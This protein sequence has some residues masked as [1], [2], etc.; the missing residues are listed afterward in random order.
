MSPW[1]V[2]VATVVVGALVPRPVALAQPFCPATATVLVVAENLSADDVVGVKVA[3]ELLD[4]DAT[5]Q[6]EGRASY[7]EDLT[8]VGR[9]FVRCGTI[10]GL[11]PGAWANRILLGVNDP[12][13]GPQSQ[14]QQAVFIAG[15]PRN[16]ANIL[17]WTVYPRTYVVAEATQAALQAR[18]DAAAA[19]TATHPGPALITFSPLAFPGAHAPQTITLADSRCDSDGT[20]CAGIRLE[21]SRL[22]VDAL[23]PRGAG[24]A[25]VL[26]A[27]PGRHEVVR[28]LGGGNVLRGLRLVGSEA[29]D[30]R[31]DTLVLS[32]P[33]ARG[34]RI[35]Q[36]LIVGPARGDAVGVGERA[37]DAAAPN[38]VDACEVTQA[39]G[40]GVRVV[41]GA[42]AV[43]RG[44][45]IHDNRNGGVQGSLGGHVSALENVVQH[46][47]PG[48][49]SNGIAVDGVR[50]GSPST[51]VT[52]ANVV[53]FAGA[54]GLSVKDDALATFEHD[55]VA[56]NQFAGSKVETTGRGPAGAAPGASFRGVALVCNHNGGISGS[57]QSETGDEEI[58]VPCE[59]AADCCPNEDGF[60]DPTCPTEC[61]PLSFPRGFGA[62]QSREGEGGAPVVVYGDDVQPGRNAFAWNQN[63]PRGANLNLNVA[64][65]RVSA[66]GN[67]WEHC[68][69]GAVCDVAAVAA[70]DVHLAE[71]A[72]VDLGE[73]AGPRAGAPVLLAVTP[74]RPRKGDLVRVFGENFNAVEGTTCAGVTGPGARPCAVTNL[75]VQN[76]NRATNATRIRI[77]APN[78]A[79]ETLYPDAVTPTMLAFHMPFDCF[80]PLSLRVAKLRADGQRIERGIPFCD[81]GGCLGA[82]AGTPCDDGSA[83][84]VDDRC[85]GGGAPTCTGTA[86]VCEGVCVTCNPEQGCVPSPAST[87]CDDGDVCTLGDHCAGREPTCVPGAPGLCDDG[88][89]CTDGVCEPGVGCVFGFNVA[90]CND[91]DPCTLD[92]TCAD[93][94]CAG[95]PLG[96]EDS[97]VCNGTETCNP[98]LGCVRGFP[99][100]CGDASDCTVP[101]VMC[102][103]ETVRRI[104]SE[105]PVIDCGGR[106]PCGFQRLVD[107]AGRLIERA[108]T[109]GGPAECRRRLRAATRTARALRQRLVRLGTRGCIAPIDRLHLLLDEALRLRA[110]AAMLARGFCARL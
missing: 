85:T 82:A 94:T 96:C 41:G 7:L 19:Y 52:V 74:P 54:R 69:E 45:C 38:V 57:C 27:G 64:G 42:H 14:G 90:R 31:H 65:A 39:Q 97:D 13:S 28:V 5:C 84:T 87:P 88:D 107:R 89:P 91:G 25:V 55:Y 79:V 23:D 6:G 66:V 16:A 24:G 40:K 86:L 3:G 30:A 21:G 72:A 50:G 67:Q 99:P 36:C 101:G 22:V 44:S 105:P 51:L 4:P 95:T 35:E 2:L 83:C 47:V 59:Q 12:G 81:A 92:D 76:R 10:E 33:S 61:A 8:C 1:S 98:D 18:L 20:R 110:R 62:A 37:G 75:A 53:R 93:G 106:C 11:R 100:V 34:N 108:T 43:V 68:G 15:A 17:A 78:G 71:G 26:S 56:D 29:V 46:N 63:A 9:G 60:P 77:V 80:A 70:E 104:A 73:P 102:S 48:P 109:T 32:G 58:P 103:V 49:A